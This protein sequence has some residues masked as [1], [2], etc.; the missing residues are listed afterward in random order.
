VT[1]PAPKETGFLRSGG[2]YLLAGA[3]L[4]S[5]VVAWRVG[6]L[7]AERRP[8][9]V[10][11][12]RTVSSYG[13]DLATL[14]VP[15]E[16]VVASGAVKD[17]VPALVD[18]ASWSLAEYE[19]ARAARRRGKLLVPGDRVLGVSL[20]GKRRAYPL[21]FLVWHEVVND[22]LGGEPIA[23]T[24]SPL[25]DSAAAF[26]R[27]V[28]GEVLTFGVSGLL[29]NSSLLLYDRR[30]GGAGESLWSQLLA[31]AVAGPAAARGDGLAIVAATL[32][33]WERWSSAHPDTTLLAP[34][35]RLAGEY[36]REPYSS[37]FGS[38]LLRFPVAPLP[39]REEA[40]FKTPVVAVQTPSGFA[41]M[42][43]PFPGAS[44]AGKGSWTTTI[45]GSALVFAFSSPPQAIT[46]TTP[47]GEP[48]AA[49]HAAYFAW[50]ATH[51]DDTTWVQL[52]E[53]D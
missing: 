42:R 24:Y 9:A 22:T 12:G 49:F 23:V 10:G 39:P 34:D 50:H 40:P 44:D 28:S 53:E 31:R 51:R 21:R 30:R 27:T 1:A 29:Y 33:T 26:R 32:T 25:S 13:F 41:A 7:L 3:L 20:G 14:A 48:A 37:Y 18:P 11:D 15:A 46:V 47:A 35:P 19:A 43:F 4:T 45:A 16:L 6:T 52:P 8:R 17:G 36:K 38:D 5:A 2:W